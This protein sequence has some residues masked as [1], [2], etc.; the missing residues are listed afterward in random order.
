MTV[1]T[2]TRQVG[3]T[4]YYLGRPATFWL[5]VMASRPTTRK[6]PCDPDLVVEQPR[7]AARAA[8]EAK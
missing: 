2:R 3:A 8:S 1:H 5:N 4:H 6:P 7:R